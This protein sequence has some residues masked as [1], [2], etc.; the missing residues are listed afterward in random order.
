MRGVTVKEFIAALHGPAKV[1]RDLRLPYMT[2]VSWGER[3]RIP[4]WRM[5]DLAKLAHDQG[6][7]VP[8]SFDASEDAAA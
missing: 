2:V 7:T 4:S 1:A 3:N 8:G 5:P 6:V